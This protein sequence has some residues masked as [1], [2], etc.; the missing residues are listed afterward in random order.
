MKTLLK[1]RPRIAAA[2]AAMCIAGGIV[3]PAPAVAQTLSIT[4]GDRILTDLHEGGR[5]GCTAGYLDRN[6]RTLRVVGHCS[7]GQNGNI[8]RDTY[9]RV[10]GRVIHNEYKGQAQPKTD[11]SVISINPDV[12]IGGNIYSGDRWAPPREIRPGDRL[13]SRSSKMNTTLCGNV[14]YVDG[15]AIIATKNAGGIPGDSGGP[16]WV[17]GKGFIGSY[18]GVTEQTTYFTYPNQN[19]QSYANAWINDRRKDIENIQRT[20]VTNTLNA[21]TAFLN[22]LEH[23]FPQFKPQ[24]QQLRKE[25]GV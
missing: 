2:I 22:D 19:P 17:P 20:V 21:I 14:L 24:I 23:N 16:G 5:V 18:V 9:G 15:N 12:Q 25:F 1:K 13:C 6:I 8:V 3:T 10:I 7:H 11:I 4:Q